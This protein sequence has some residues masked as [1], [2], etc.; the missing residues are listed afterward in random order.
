ME[1]GDIATAV[2]QR[3]VDNFGQSCH[4]LLADE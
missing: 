4:A 1:E 3:S 2:G